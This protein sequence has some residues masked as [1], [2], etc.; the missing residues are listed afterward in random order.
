M[1]AAIQIFELYPKPA[2]AMISGAI[3]MRGVTCSA[4][5]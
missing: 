3:A 2:Q 5:A 4:T 1:I